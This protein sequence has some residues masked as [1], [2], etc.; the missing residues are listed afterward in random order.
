L[1]ER[2]SGWLDST[3]EITSLVSDCSAVVHMLHLCQIPENTPLLILAAASHTLPIIRFGRYA[4]CLIATGLPSVYSE[5]GTHSDAGTGMVLTELNSIPGDALIHRPMILP[6]CLD[7]TAQHR[8]R[9]LY[10]LQAQETC[11]V[12]SHGSPFPSSL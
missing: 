1:S 9:L 10:I 4:P 12:H 7:S 2:D 11:H 6:I 8:D 3:E 5:V